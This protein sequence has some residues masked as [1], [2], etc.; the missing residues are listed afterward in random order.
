[1][2]KQTCSS[3]QEKVI[4]LNVGFYR[5]IKLLQHCMKAFEQVFDSKRRQQVKTYD[6]DMQFGLS[7]G[8]S[9]TDAIFKIGMVQKK[10]I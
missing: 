4:H 7:I 3:L 8:K 9:I 1:M 6:T 5:A 10:F 2:E